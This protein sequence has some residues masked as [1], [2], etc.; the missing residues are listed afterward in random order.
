MRAHGVEINFICLEAQTL[1]KKRFSF[2]VFFIAHSHCLATIAIILEFICDDMYCDGS[3]T[4]MC[5]LNIFINNFLL[6]CRQVK[7]SLFEI[8]D[9]DLLFISSVFQPSSDVN[10]H[11]ILQYII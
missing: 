10:C 11:P 8:L 7:I 9:S 2:N 5:S 4:I 1:A 6:P 3:I